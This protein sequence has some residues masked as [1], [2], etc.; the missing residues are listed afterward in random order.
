MQIMQMK[1]GQVWNR[2]NGWHRMK[3]NRRVCG[4]ATACQGVPSSFGLN[5]RQSRLSEKSN[6]IYGKAQDDVTA[7][8]IGLQELVDA[9]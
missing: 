6:Q 4:M 3:L 9:A 8:S 1:H 2:A 5:Q 7:Q